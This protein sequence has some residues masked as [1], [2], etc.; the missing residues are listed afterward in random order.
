MHNSRIFDRWQL[1]AVAG[2][3]TFLPFSLATPRRVAST[4]LG[5]ASRAFLVLDKDGLTQLSPPEAQ[6]G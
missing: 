1:K 4:A 2:G 3:F 6:L 5:S